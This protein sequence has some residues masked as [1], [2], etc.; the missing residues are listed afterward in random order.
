M[1][2]K[3]EGVG[4]E[5]LMTWPLAKELFFGTFRKINL[6]CDQ[7]FLSIM[8]SPRAIKWTR[9]HDH[10]LNHLCQWGFPKATS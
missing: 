1:A 7:E 9:L 2:I 10:M 6:L 3:L 4:G 5:A 8:I